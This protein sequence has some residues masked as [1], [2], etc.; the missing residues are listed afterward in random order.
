MNQTQDAVCAVIYHL[1]KPPFSSSPEQTVDIYLLT[2]REVALRIKFSEVSN[3]AQVARAIFPFMKSLKHYG[4]YDVEYILAV[5]PG[6]PE[7][8]YGTYSQNFANY[9]QKGKSINVRLQI[10]PWNDLPIEGTSLAD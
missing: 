6:L 10:L 2:L 4:N 9:E 8:V 7:A 1:E 3:R 5:A